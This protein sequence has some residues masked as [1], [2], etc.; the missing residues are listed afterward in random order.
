MY[1]EFKKTTKTCFSE[2]YLKPYQLSKMER[3]A[4]KFNDSKLLT[5]FA[6]RAI[7]EFDRVLNTTLLLI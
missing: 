2:A 7:L 1:S 5:I 4:K 6:E 3:F